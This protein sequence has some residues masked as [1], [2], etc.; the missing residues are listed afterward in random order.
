MARPS[1]GFPDRL[2]ARARSEAAGA[3]RRTTDGADIAR[4][5]RGPQPD[6]LGHDA[7]VFAFRT[8]LHART[9]RDI[10]RDCQP[11]EYGG[12]ALKDHAPF[13]A[14]ALDRLAAQQDVARGWRQEAGDHPKDRRLPAPA[15]SE[16]TEGRPG[17]K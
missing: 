2:P 8:A 12:V 7:P 14:G 9:E 3:C 13:D 17:Q 5:L 11:V 15:G 16:P 6:V 10:L 4:N 1:G